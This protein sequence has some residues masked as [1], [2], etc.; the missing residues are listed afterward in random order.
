MPQILNKIFQ[1]LSGCV[2]LALLACSAV[3]PAGGPEGIL[4]VGGTGDGPPQGSVIHTGGAVSAA[5]PV[6]DIG[7]PGPGQYVYPNYQRYIQVKIEGATDSRNS[8]STN[9]NSKVSVKLFGTI[10]SMPY[11]GVKDELDDGV[12]FLKPQ[13]YPNDTLIRVKETVRDECLETRLFTRDGEASRY[14]FN[15]L[16]DRTG[17]AEAFDEGYYNPEKGFKRNLSFMFWEVKGYTP[18]TLNQW[19]PCSNYD[20]NTGQ[21]EIPP[22]IPRFQEMPQRPGSGNDSN[23]SDPT[24]TLAPDLNL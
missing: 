11:P 24:Q 13:S 8:S 4:S 19:Q 23:N 10:L 6:Y 14:E 21:L 7:N 1:C 17:G 16:V 15:I 2:V 18:L 5:A 20:W 3:G 12:D 9:A 22:R